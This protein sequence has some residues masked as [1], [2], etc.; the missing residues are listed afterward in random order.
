MYGIPNVP[1]AR[2]PG[3]E[4]PV[5][6]IDG[7]PWLSSTALAALLRISHDNL[8]ITLDSLDIT[9]WARATHFQPATRNGVTLKV[10]ISPHGFALLCEI[11][12]ALREAQPVRRLIDNLFATLTRP[13]PPPIPPAKGWRGMLRWLG[14]GGIEA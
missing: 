12:P 8:L 13:T 3:A 6:R 5:I 11:M 2:R 10:W 14:L 4:P 1:H 7:H 9:G